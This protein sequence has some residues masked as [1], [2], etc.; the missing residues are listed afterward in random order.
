MAEADDSE[1]NGNG[2]KK[3]SRLMVIGGLVIVLLI[4]VGGAYKFLLAGK[5]SAQHKQA[6]PK[7]ALFI[8]LDPFVSNVNASDG[9]H[10]VQVT[11]ELKTFQPAAKKEVN[12]DMPEIRNAIL[13]LLAQQN[14]YRMT[15]P[16]SRVRL[17]RIIRNQVNSLLT[18][19]S[20][21]P[22]TSTI[23][24][25]TANTMAAHPRTSGSRSG[26]AHPALMPKAIPGPIQGVYFTAF[27]VQ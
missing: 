15:E 17:R 3:H 22:H 11:M 19:S 26:S 24:A 9:L 12:Q 5:S 27:V 14:P 6:T 4:I 23:S 10:Y 2:K 21:A 18:R 16:Q 1:N 20:S 25:T 7:K 8:K 13:N